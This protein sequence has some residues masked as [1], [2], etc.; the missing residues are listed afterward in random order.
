VEQLEKAG[1]NAWV[2]PEACLVT[3]YLGV[4]SGILA[5][6]EIAEAQESAAG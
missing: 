4:R 2:P 1:G 6:V 3:G 5:M